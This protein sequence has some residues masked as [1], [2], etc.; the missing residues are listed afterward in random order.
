[1]EY[2]EVAA[3]GDAVHEPAPVIRR[4]DQGIAAVVLGTVE[5]CVHLMAEGTRSSIE[6][7]AAYRALYLLIL[8]R[9][10]ACLRRTVI[11]ILTVR[12]EGREYLQVCRR[13]QLWCQ[14]QLVGADIQDYDVTELVVGLDAL[15]LAHKEALMHR[16]G[17]VGAVVA[18]G[19]PVGIGACCLRRVGLGVEPSLPSVG[20]LHQRASTLTAYLQRQLARVSTIRSM[21]VEATAWYCGF[22]HDSIFVKRMDVALVDANVAPHL[23]AWSYA[24]VGDSVF[25]HR[26]GAY[27]DYKVL[28]LQPLAILSG[29]DGQRQ[30]ASLVLSS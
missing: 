18:R 20:Q 27:I 2:R 23:V 17:G 22:P 15:S 25:V 26:I 3:T 12:R 8:R 6:G 28:V 11:Q 5:Q 7:D 24:T 30:P 4:T 1:M 21:A 16:V 13:H 14:Y 10:T 9:H 19:M 29:A